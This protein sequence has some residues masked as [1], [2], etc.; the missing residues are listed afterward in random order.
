MLPQLPGGS[1]PCVRL[2]DEAVLS[3]A[4]GVIV[5]PKQSCPRPHRSV[6]CQKR[7]VPSGL[8]T[9]RGLHGEKGS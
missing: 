6:I 2:S 7:N 9:L 8:Y 3:V 4:G 1:R 5:I